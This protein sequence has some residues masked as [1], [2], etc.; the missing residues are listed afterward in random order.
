LAPPASDS[1][2]FTI[3]RSQRWGTLIDLSLLDTRQY[4]SDQAC[5]DITLS[6]DPACPET[7]LPERTLLGEEQETWLF[8]RLGRQGATWNVLAQQ[9]IM[10]DATLNGAVLNFDQWDGYPADR[11]RVLQH[12]V[13]AG[14]DNFVVLTGDIHFAGIGNL[15]APAVAGAPAETVRPTIGAEFVASSISSSGNVPEAA[16]PIVQSIPT[17]VDIELAHRGWV[18]H[19]V[20]PESWTADYRIVEDSTNPASPSTTYRRFVVDAGQPGARPLEP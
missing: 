17:I 6:L 9:V 16:A 8:D 1:A 14:V 12:V 7:Y 10:T 3:Y 2:D 15:L 19:T 4:R 11:D 18:K 5:N 13:D 20:T